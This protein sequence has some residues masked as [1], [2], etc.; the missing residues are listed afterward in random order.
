MFAAGMSAGA[1]IGAVGGFLSDIAVDEATV[2][3]ILK[4][5]EDAA[6]DLDKPFEPVPPT[7]FGGSSSGCE[8]GRHTSIAQEH[9]FNAM[10]DMVK[11]LSGFQQ[12]VTTYAADQGRVDEDSGQQ[13]LRIQQAAECLAVP[14]LRANNEC[15]P[16]GGGN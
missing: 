4:I 5:L 14:D 9:V 13:S 11:A 1:T 12:S 10:M 8:L 15:A 6:S 16:T 2:Q 7:A 3:R